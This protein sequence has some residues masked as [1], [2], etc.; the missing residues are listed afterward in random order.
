MNIEVVKLDMPVSVE[1]FY[2]EYGDCPA[3]TLIFLQDKDPILLGDGYCQARGTV[4]GYSAS[5]VPVVADAKRSL[6]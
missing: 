1:D 4:I 5:L 3:G 2:E 6:T